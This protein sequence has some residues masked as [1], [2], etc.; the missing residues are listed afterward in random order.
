[1][2]IFTPITTEAALDTDMAGSSNVSSSEFV[3]LY[4]SA[5][6]GT[7]YL[8]TIQ[9]GGFTDATCDYDDDPT[10]TCDANTNIKAGLFVS[11]TGIPDHAYVDAVTEGGGAGTGV[12][13]F[14]L[15]ASTTGGAVS[16]GT[17]TFASKLG[18]FSLEGL[19]TAIIRKASTDKLFAANAAVLAC[20]V[21][22][23]EVG[24]PREYSKS[25]N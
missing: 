23:V 6:A 22:I 5:A 8:I 10:I 15:S 12:T 1:M 7:E 21:S 9:T 25:A 16:N 24:Q 20:G 13:T 17:L 14:E 4:N 3:R 19:D 11:G 18:T 2:T